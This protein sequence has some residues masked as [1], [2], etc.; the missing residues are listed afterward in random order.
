MGIDYGSRRVGVA[1]SDPL[2]ILAG[3]LA[4]LAN[5][6]ALIDRLCALAAE[7]EAVLVVVGMPYAADGGKGGKAR[8]VEEF[9]GRLRARLP[10]P[11]ETW[12]ESY[13]SVDAHRAFLAGGMKRK[14]RQQKSRVDVMAARLLL[15]EYLEH[16]HAVPP[17]DPD[18]RGRQ[19]GPP[20][21]P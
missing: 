4:A 8:E 16:L 12:D 13:T 5:D 19:D 9:L 20:A 6:G 17:T 10:V 11:V 21:M 18:S 3:P 2:R 15:Q 14:R 7:Q 1:V